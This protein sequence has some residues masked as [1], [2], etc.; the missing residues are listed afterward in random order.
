MTLNEDNGEERPSALDATPAKHYDIISSS[1]LDSNSSPSSLPLTKILIVGTFIIIIGMGVL[2]LATIPPEGSPL[3]GKALNDDLD[4]KIQLL[5][6][7]ESSLSVFNGTPIILDLMATWCPP[8]LEQIAIF[9]SIKIYYPDVQII[10]VTIDLRDTIDKLSKFKEEQEINW[11][12]GRDITGKGAQTYL[13]PT[14]GIPILVY[15]NSNGIIKKHHEGKVEY[16]TLS[17]W[18]NKYG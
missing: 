3:I 4:F 17:S 10:S 8:C 15:F 16:E 7:N 2:S 6:E 1:N 11:I 13:F 9:K 18:I 5:D 14:A 12:V